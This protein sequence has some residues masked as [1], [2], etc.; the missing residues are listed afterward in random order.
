MGHGHEHKVKEVSGNISFLTTHFK[1]NCSL[2]YRLNKAWYEEILT[3][4]EWLV[5]GSI[6]FVY[7]T[8]R[9]EGIESH[10]EWLKM[11]DKL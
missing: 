3:L 1:F 6:H 8:V 4:F 5:E 9:E 10:S 7:E 2:I 11:K